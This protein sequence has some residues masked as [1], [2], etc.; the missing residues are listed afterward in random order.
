MSAAAGATVHKLVTADGTYATQSAFSASST[1]KTKKQAERPPL[2][3]YLME[4][5]FFIGA[6]IGSTMTKLA[7][8]YS[9]IV[10]DEKKQNRYFQCCGSGGMIS[11][12]SGYDFL[13][14][15][16]WTLRYPFNLSIFENYFYKIPKT[17]QKGKYAN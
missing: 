9:S 1:D 11:S 10:H 17:N 12:G 14:F 6:S 16:I 8:R 4:G 5:D 7:L 15:R 3:K 2:R 13:E